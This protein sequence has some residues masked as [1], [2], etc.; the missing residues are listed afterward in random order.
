M[1]K[2]VPGS[3]SVGPVIEVIGENS[4]GRGRI[5]SARESENDVQLTVEFAPQAAPEGAPEAAGCPLFPIGTSVEIELCDP[6]DVKRR[7]VTRRSGR[8]VERREGAHV[9]LYG[10]FF[11]NEG[12]GPLG[13]LANRREAIRVRPTTDAPTRAQLTT[14]TSDDWSPAGVIDLSITGVA[15]VLA[16]DQDQAFVE[17]EELR[18][19]V[20]LP[21]ASMPLEFHAV[22]R[23][24]R[25]VGASIHYGLE[26]LEEATRGFYGKQE[27]L[28]RYVRQREEESTAQRRQSA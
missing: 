5:V 12:K 20:Q 4:V 17:E 7:R 24:R 11:P 2:S 16:E 15:L 25:L 13:S 28:A 21:K 8:I 23:Y 14:L 19:R 9:R 22:I 26:F 18:V 1:K 10:I 27:H 6:N 3:D